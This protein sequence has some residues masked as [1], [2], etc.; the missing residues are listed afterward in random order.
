M[1]VKF[2]GDPMAE[3]I[4]AAEFLY[5]SLDVEIYVGA[6]DEEESDAPLGRTVWPDDGSPVYITIS[7]DC[8]LCAMPEIMAHEIAHV[9]AGI[10]A[11]HGDAWEAEFSRIHEQ[12]G[13]QMEQLGY[14][15]EGV[16]YVECAPKESV[17]NHAE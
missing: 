16:K 4:K 8:P 13:K 10:D 15:L 2:V 5:P 1:P 6:F 12:Y 7:L 9:V 3:I 11:E 14:E 17:I